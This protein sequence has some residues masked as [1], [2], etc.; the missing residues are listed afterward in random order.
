MVDLLLVFCFLCMFVL[1]DFLFGKEYNL[2]ILWLYFSLLF[3][4]FKFF[5]SV[6]DII[7][8]ILVLLNKV[9]EN[10]FILFRKVN[11][12]IFLNKFIIINIIMFKIMICY[13]KNNNDFSC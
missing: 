4:L 3:L 9:I 13:L 11:F 2:F 8:F 5:L 6:V 12:G 7:F 1:L 10:G